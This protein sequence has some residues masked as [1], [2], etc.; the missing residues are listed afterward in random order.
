MKMQPDQGCRHPGL[1]G[2]RLCYDGLHDL[3]RLGARV[4]NCGNKPYPY[5]YHGLP[6]TEVAR[7]RGETKQSIN[8]QP[9]E[10]AIDQIN[11]EF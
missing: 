9:M 11:W 3:L 10:V 2:H 4:V 5:P 7:R 1:P 6:W 8:R